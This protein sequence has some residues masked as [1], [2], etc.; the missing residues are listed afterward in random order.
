MKL[1]VIR[2]KASSLRELGRESVEVPAVSTLE[3]LLG[4]MVAAELR[5][6]HRQSAASIP[7]VLSGEEI[8]NQSRLGRVSFSAPYEE[9]TGTLESAVQVMLQDFEDGLFRVY[10]N[11]KECTDLKEHLEV[12]DGDE[13]VFIRFVMLAG[14]MW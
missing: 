1:N 9:N 12:K 8:K 14:R 11:G 6:H 2:K 13:I 3:E 4:E 5:K 10:L 7:E